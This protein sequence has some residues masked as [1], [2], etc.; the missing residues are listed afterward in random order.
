[1][2]VPD[3]FACNVQRKANVPEFANVRLIVAFELT[4]MSA[5]ADVAEALPPKVSVEVGAVASLLELQPYRR[6]CDRENRG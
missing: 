4:G 1:M 5:G 2:T 6:D 3:I